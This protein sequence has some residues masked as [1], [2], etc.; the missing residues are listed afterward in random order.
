MSEINFD[1]LSQFFAQVPSVQQARIIAHGADAQHAWWFKFSIDVEH[2]L[3]WQTVQEL[4]H[5]LNYLSTNERLPTL[6]F[7]VSP[8]PYMNGEA[9]DFLAW[10]IQCNHADFPPDVICD[11]LEGRLPSPVADESQ[12]K[13]KTDIQELDAVSD[14]DLDELVPPNP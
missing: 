14:K 6:F 2:A 12:W 11:W 7:P 13:I 5:V 1:R 9:N 3:A 8:P 10:V 4:G